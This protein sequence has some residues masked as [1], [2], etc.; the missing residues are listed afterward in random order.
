MSRNITESIDATLK[1]LT[2]TL[3]KSSG[4]KKSKGVHVCSTSALVYFED[5]VID[6]AM[7]TNADWRAGMYFN[8]DVAS[9]SFFTIL[10]PPEVAELYT[11]PRHNI[12][13]GC[14]I[15]AHVR[16]TLC[17]DCDLKKNILFTF[18]ISLL[19]RLK[20]RAK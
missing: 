19:F 1:R 4:S 7:L 17:R 12:M 18:Y 16:F 8:I 20:I 2:I 13:E 10:N 14:K 6:S 5:T 15:I 3:G 11:F 9:I